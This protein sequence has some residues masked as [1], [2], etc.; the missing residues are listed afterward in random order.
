MFFDILGKTFQIFLS[1][2]SLLVYPV[3]TW[4]VVNFVSTF[5]LTPI[6]VTQNLLIMLVVGLP[7]A[8]VLG[9]I[10]LM[11]AVASCYM[12]F[13]QLKGEDVSIMDGVNLAIARF[14]QIA[15]FIGFIFLV[16]LVG[17]VVV[18]L[19]LAVPA[20]VCLAFILYIGV[21]IFAL[22]TM[23]VY[24]VIAVEGLGGQAAYR[25]SAQLVNNTKSVVGFIVLFSLI[26]GFILSSVLTGSI[27]SRDI[28]LMQRTG[29]YPPI[30]G[31]LANPLFQFVSSILTSM[32]GSIFT[33]V[34]YAKAIEKV[35]T[36]TL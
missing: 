23:L 28:E 26:F 15:A 30:L 24:A 29:T 16:S 2:P 32:F 19:I 17:L 31:F 4:L 3:A 6:L 20:L 5:L 34:W 22:S 33:A 10:S 25:R 11:G 1:T 35:D 36:P 18:A 12:V 13:K 21:I 9:V 14:K 27:T 7:M 8:F